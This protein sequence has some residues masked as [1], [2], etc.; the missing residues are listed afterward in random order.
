MSKEEVRAAANLWGRVWNEGRLDLVSEALAASYIR[1]E[2]NG[3]RTVT[4]EQYR[5]EIAAMQKRIPDIHFTF[6]DEAITDNTWWV[7][8]TL[9]GTNAETSEPATRS[10]LQVYRIANGRLVETWLA[11]HGGGPTW[12]D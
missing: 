7:R 8:W 4:M 2:P 1:H 5:E 6:H 11:P 12:G 9:N 10:G 3:T